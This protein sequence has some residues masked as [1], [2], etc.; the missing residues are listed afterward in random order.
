MTV[1]RALRDSPSVTPATKR[2]VLSVCRKL[3][4]RPNLVASGLRSRKSYAIGI[5][6]PTFKHTFYARLLNRVED[7]ARKA[8]YHI[9]VFQG[10][11]G[12]AQLVMTWPDME[13]LLARQIDGLLIDLE[14]P[15]EIVRNLKKERIPAVFVDIPP[16]DND[17][18]FVGTADFDGSREL[19]NYLI[20]LGHRRILFLGGPADHYTSVQR[21][22]G[23]RAAL[24]ENG[25]VFSGDLVRHTDYDTEGGYQ[26][27]REL[28]V[29]QRNFTAIFGVNDYIAIG[30]LSALTEKGISVPGDVSVVGFTGDDIGAHTIPPLTTMVQPVEEIGGRAVEILFARIT[31]SKRPVERL[32]LPARLM[33]RRSARRI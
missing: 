18:P 33:E 13:F 31:D 29:G 14:L 30:A 26:T 24:R 2:R 10:E 22:A 12:H 16:K 32:L 21:F 15:S 5:I 17:F 7:E 9:V 23:Y 6:I 25:L 4:Y 20:S 3:N 8:G 28:L 27:C 11:R 19:T 1:T